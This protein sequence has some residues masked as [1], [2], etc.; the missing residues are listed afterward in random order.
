MSQEIVFIES[1]RGLHNRI[2]IRRTF[3]VIGYES[4]VQDKVIITV[5]V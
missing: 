5:T 1:H 3:D 2:Q 4:W